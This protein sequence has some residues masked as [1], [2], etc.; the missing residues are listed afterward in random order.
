MLTVFSQIVDT[1]QLKK[2]TSLFSLHNPAPKDASSISTITDA[3]SLIL[4]QNVMQMHHSFKSA[5]RKSWIRL[6]MHSHKYPLRENAW[7]Y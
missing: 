2:T 1:F 3:S 5:I 4:K 6:Y 7:G